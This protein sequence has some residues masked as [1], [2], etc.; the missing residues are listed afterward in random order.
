MNVKDRWGERPLDDAK[1]AKKNGAAIADILTGAG[2]VTATDQHKADMHELKDQ[3]PPQTTVVS[4]EEEGMTQLSV[5][6]FA[7]GCSVLHQ[8]AL[9]NQLVLEKMFLERPALVNFQDYDR[10]SRTNSS[11]LCL[12]SLL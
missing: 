9:G 7:V 3:A 11:L 4:M 6:E 5:Q 12:F 2:G 1:K 10:R 8:A